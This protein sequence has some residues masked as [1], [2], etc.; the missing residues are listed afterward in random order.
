LKLN[1]YTKG[2]H[3]TYRTPHPNSIKCIAVSSDGK[4]IMTG[5]YTGTLAGFDVD[6]KEWASFSRPTA[7]GIS[8][9]AY[10]PQSDR[11]L[12]SSYNGKIYKVEE[13]ANSM[14]RYRL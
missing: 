6:K 8:A 9:I 11:F 7:S 4:R 2:A 12:A 14:C 13:S 1:L 5:S 10:N 3:T